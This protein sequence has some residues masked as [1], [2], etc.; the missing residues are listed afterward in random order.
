MFC[1]EN[2][3]QIGYKLSAKSGIIILKCVNLVTAT[4]PL[5]EDESAQSRNDLTGIFKK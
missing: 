1:M 3:F 4:K 2:Y 5:V